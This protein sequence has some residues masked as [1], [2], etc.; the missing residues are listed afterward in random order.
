MPGDL[1]RD[2]HLGLRARLAELEVRIRDTEAE[3]T[4]AFWASLDPRERERLSA[5]RDALELV[6]SESF[7]E[8][9]RAEQLLSSYADELARRVAALPGLEEEWCALP[10]EAPDPP[11][12]RE[13]WVLGLPSQAETSQLVRAFRAMVR[14]RDRRAE[15][16]DG[17]R[18]C[19]ARFRDRNAPFSLRATAYTNGN[20]QIA[21]VAMWL[22]TSVPRAAPRLVVRHESLVQAFGKALGLKHEV[23]VGEPSFDGLFLIEGSK[24]AADRLLVPSV[25][26]MLLTLARFDVPTLDID[27]PRRVASLRW[28]FEPAP[29]ALEAAVG[30]L[31]TIREAEAVVRFRR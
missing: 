12:E 18:S 31:A 16:V 1:Y 27:P 2:A 29:K 11:L 30:V 4:D 25:Q 9:A 22:M 6:R 13:P 24:E 19:L 3:L 26:T 5:L 10:D 20:G 8:L 23:E 17:K 28:R 21:E 15:V 14:E 7:E